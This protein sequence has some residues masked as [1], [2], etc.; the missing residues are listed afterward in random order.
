LPTFPFLSDEL[1]RQVRQH[2][3]LRLL[4]LSNN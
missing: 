4:R 3:W 1:S 2:A